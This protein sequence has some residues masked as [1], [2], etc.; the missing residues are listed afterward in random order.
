MYI[1]KYKY[2]YICSYIRIYISQAIIGRIKEWSAEFL[3]V[4][5]EGLK[6]YN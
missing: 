2:I 3:E 5:L 1:Y 4:C 6:G